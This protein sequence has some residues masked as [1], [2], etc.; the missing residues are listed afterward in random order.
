MLMKL[1]ILPGEDRV[2]QQLRRRRQRQVRAQLTVLTDQQ[3]KLQRLKTLAIAKHHRTGA[4]TE[5]AGHGGFAGV[6]VGAGLGFSEQ[7]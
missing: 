6:D 3:T 1:A 7:A 2:D 5:A 4:F